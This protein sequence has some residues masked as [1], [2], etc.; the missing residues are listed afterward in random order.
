MDKNNEN[1]YITLIDRNVLGGKDKDAKVH[2]KDKL[3]QQITERIKQM[4]LEEVT[5]SD[6]IQFKK[7]MQTLFPYF[8]LF[9]FSTC[10]IIKNLL[11]PFDFPSFATCD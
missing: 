1:V 9:P 3:G 8:P 6:C 5:V 2:T 11:I 4:W 10:A 7:A